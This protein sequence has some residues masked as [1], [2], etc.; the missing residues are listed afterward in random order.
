MIYIAFAWSLISQA[1][2]SFSMIM[3]DRRE[4][5]LNYIRCDLLIQIPDPA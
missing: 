1:N 5:I 3:A 4:N 2:M